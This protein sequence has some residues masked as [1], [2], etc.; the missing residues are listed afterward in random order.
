MTLLLLGAS[1][2]VGSE[3]LA[4]A[5]AD[6]RVTA[7]VAPTRHPLPAQPKLQNP[8]A[9]ELESLLPQVAV[10]H[11]DAIVC[12]LGT[13]MAKAGTQAAFRRVDHDLPLA[14]ATAARRTGTA[15]FALTSSMG[16]SPSS[17]FFYMR[18]KGELERDLEALGF[19][20]LLIVR[21]SLIGGARAESRRREGATLRL[22]TFLNPVLP[23]S[24]R[25]SPASK[26]A[27]LLLEGA[28]APVPGR[29]VVSA[30]SLAA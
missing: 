27:E 28:V 25:V 15:T 24:T 13:T 30:D 3:V 9:A 26:I 20:S 22:M 7:L 19:P 18:T 23:R 12:A 17:R 1:G 4:R 10:W 5:L 8:V 29:R 21:P 14:F 11:A 16:A 2:L 6:A